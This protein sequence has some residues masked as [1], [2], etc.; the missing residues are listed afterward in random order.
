MRELHRMLEAR[1]KELFYRLQEITQG[2]LKSLAAQ[3]DQLETTQAQLHSCEDFLRQSIKTGCLSEV[4]KMR[5]TIVH[6]AKK[7]TTEF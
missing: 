3:K 7:L 1:K 5:K 2:K 6:K 4:L